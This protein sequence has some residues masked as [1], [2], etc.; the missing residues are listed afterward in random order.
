MFPQKAVFEMRISCFKLVSFDKIWRDSL[1][2]DHFL[3]LNHQ[4]VA[5]DY[6][7]AAPFLFAPDAPLPP[8]GIPP[9]D[10]D[11]EIRNNRPVLSF[12]HHYTPILSS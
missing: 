6:P 3:L 10:R 8:K 1:Y 11:G 4:G 7:V 2:P 12:K 5:A 9:T